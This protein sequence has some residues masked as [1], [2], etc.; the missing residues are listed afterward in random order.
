MDFCKTQFDTAQKIE[1]SIKDLFSKYGHRK[2]E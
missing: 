1:F 2:F